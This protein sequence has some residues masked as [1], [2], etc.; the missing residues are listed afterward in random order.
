MGRS[1]VDVVD[2]QRQEPYGRES[3]RELSVWLW[4]PAKPAPGSRKGAYLPGAWRRAA[5]FWGV[6]SKRVRP[7]AIS[8][9][10]VSDVGAPHPVLV[11]SPS[12]FPPLFYTALFEEL[13]SHGYVVAAVSHTYEMLPVSVFADGRVR[14]FRPASLGGAFAVSRGPQAEDVRKRAAV[15]EVKAADL[16]SV[17]ARLEQL[18]TEPGR[19]TGKLDLGRLGAMGH[20]FGG[21]AA[22]ELCVRDSRCRAVAILDGG[23]WTAV[24]RSGLGL[25]VLELFGEHPEYVQPCG[26]SVRRNVFT[27][28]EYCRAD[29]HYVLRGWQR[30]HEAA[31]PGY[32]LL[33]RGAGHASFTDCG[34]LPLR[35]WSPAAQALGTIEGARM[36]R[37]LGDC[38]RAFFDRHVKGGPAPLLD[39]P[40]QVYPEVVSAAPEVLFPA[41]A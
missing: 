14:W 5:F 27:S 17:V 26:E 9:A 6:R 37:V 13:A 19:F 22:A 40:T 7:H 32:S 39:D 18:N 23:L 33:I 38:L 29:Q 11:F 2:L 15:V 24:A 30:V 8:E 4:Y 34:L 28:E 20:S 1:A 10:P 3:P 41:R 12:G 21:N 25:P 35:R 31:R 36:W 16:C